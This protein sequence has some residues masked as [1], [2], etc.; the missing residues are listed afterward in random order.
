MAYQQK[1]DFLLKPGRCDLSQNNIWC[2]DKFP[3][4]LL[5]FA[6]STSIIGLQLANSIGNLLWKA[7][8]CFSHK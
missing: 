6:P 8:L 5:L 1:F 7:S 4:G 3:I 2:F